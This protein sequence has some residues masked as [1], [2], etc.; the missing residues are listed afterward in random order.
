M[1]ERRADLDQVHA[2]E[3]QAG[4]T[5]DQ[6]QRLARGEPTGT[7][8]PVPGAKAGSTASMSKER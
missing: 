5:A 7:G 4:E 6:L 3:P 1:V 2:D 8:V